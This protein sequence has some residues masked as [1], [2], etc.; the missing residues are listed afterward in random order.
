MVNPDNCLK[1]SHSA[2]IF[3]LNK[4]KINK[5]TFSQNIKQIAKAIFFIF[6]FLFERGLAVQQSDQPS[7]MIVGVRRVDRSNTLAPSLST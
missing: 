6:Y 3:S 5:H 1:Q 7:T 2:K 4:I